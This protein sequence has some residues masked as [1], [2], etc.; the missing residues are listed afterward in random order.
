MMD[1]SR[2]DSPGSDYTFM[3]CMGVFAMMLGAGIS[4]GIADK[5]GYSMCFIISL[6]LIVLSI[7]IV[8]RLYKKIDTNYYWMQFNK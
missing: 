1:W 7:F 5:F 3:D 8:W 4:Y 6:P 2:N